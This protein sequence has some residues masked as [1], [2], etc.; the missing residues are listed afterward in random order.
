MKDTKIIRNKELNI[1]EALTP[2]V[3]LIILLAYNVTV[4]GDD[5]LSGS[6]QF[7]LLIGG[8]VAAIVGFRNKVGYQQM[9]DEVSNNFKSTT[10]AILILLL[11]TLVIINR[12]ILAIFLWLITFL[13]SKSIQIRQRGR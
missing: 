10:E 3:V 1:W 7:I 9:I 12:F 2:V 6:N 13:K 5:A 11:I 8:A 4:Y